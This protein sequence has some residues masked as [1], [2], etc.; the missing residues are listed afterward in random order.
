MELLVEVTV[1]G[2]A[3]PAGSKQPGMSSTGKMFVRDANPKSREWKDRVAGAA[4]EA[5]TKAAVDA[6]LHFE[7]TEY[8]VRPAGH[9]GSGRNAGIVKDSA[10]A[11]P[12]T[13]PDL[14][15]IVRGVE[16]ALTKIVW[17]DDSRVVSLTAT[18]SFGPQ[19]GVVLRVWAMDAQTAADLPLRE[20]LRDP[21][22]FSGEQQVLA[23]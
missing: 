9:Y 23:A 6:A 4:A 5:Y 21:S 12:T 17:V 1:A 20:R 19:A 11:Y 7:V 10:P 15:K 14:T 18:K 2:G 13:V 22:I 3:E 8:R 16:D